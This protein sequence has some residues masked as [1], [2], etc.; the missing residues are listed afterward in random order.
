MYLLW[1]GVLK[2]VR[3]IDL[4][5]QIYV[6]EGRNAA[7]VSKLPRKGSK[8]TVLSFLVIGA[9]N[10]IFHNVGGTVLF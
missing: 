1:V 5:L 6:K 9:M 3:R 8:S 7:H 2:Y 4:L 10:N